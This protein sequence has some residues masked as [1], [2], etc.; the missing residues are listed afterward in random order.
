MKRG[1][2]EKPE[3]WPW[4][5]FRHYLTGAE[6]VVEIESEWTTQQRERMGVRLQVKMVRK[7][8][9]FGDGMENPHPSKPGLGGAPA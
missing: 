6:G 8:V 2:V 7:P 5:S 3:D 4:S 1:L 9:S